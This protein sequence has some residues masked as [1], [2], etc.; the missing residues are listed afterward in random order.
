MKPP[1]I[2]KLASEMRHLGRWLCRNHENEVGGA[3][4]RLASHIKRRAKELENAG[5]QAQ[6]VPITTLDYTCKGIVELLERH[7][8]YTHHIDFNPWTLTSSAL[9]SPL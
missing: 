6:V 1:E 8:F 2:R 3:L 5:P 9:I 7:G 4:L